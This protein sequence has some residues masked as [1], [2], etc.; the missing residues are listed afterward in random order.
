MSTDAPEVTPQDREAVLDWL[1]VDRGV[2]LSSR[3]IAIAALRVGPL[4][5]NVRI[6]HPWDPDDLRRCLNLLRLAPSLRAVA[7][8]RLAAASDVWAELIGVWDDLDV[9]LAREGGEDYMTAHYMAP[10]TYAHMKEAIA[11]GRGET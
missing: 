7:F 4:P 2:G 3:T 6:S 10:E 1:L 11:R 8:P 9:L 5:T